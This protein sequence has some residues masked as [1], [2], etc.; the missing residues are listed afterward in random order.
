MVAM[1]LR[2]PRSSALLLI[3]CLASAAAAYRA[4]T[5]DDSGPAGLVGLL[6]EVDDAQFQLDLLTG[7]LDGLR[8]RK[9]VE[10]P[11]RWPA[12]YA[13][14]GKSPNAEVR[15]QA[16]LLALKFN[17]PQALASLRKTVTDARPFGGGSERSP[18]DGTP[19]R[20]RLAALEAL[21]EK[22]APGLAPLLHGLLDDGPLR[23]AALKG[24][25]ACDDPATPR[26]VLGRYA[27]FS[28][29]EKQEAI[30][31]LASR[32]T[33]ARA[34]LDA[35]GDD[36]VPAADVSAFTARQLRNLGDEQITRRLKEVWGEVR[37]T[38]KEKQA[39][40]AK[41]KRLLTK[42]ALSRADLGQGRRVYD[43]T[44]GKCHKLFGAGV[45]IGP[46]LTG[47]NRA[48]LHYV[49]ENV[50]DP[51]AVVAKGYR[52]T[53]VLTVDGRLIAGII[54]AET[55]ASLTL[56]TTEERV[57]IANEDIDERETPAISMMPDG[58]FDTLSDRQIC[59]LIAYLAS[60]SQVPLPP[61]KEAEAEPKP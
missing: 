34:L 19:P 39:L 26:A 45:D 13:K 31:T 49:L 37:Q 15:R 38:S 4:E 1:M 20:E 54:V 36:V 55:N 28:R 18:T 3:A 29:T 2:C 59:D 24:L 27:R 10:M 5:S 23:S 48:D 43:E 30:H 56:Q 17:D 53:N 40:I 42:A 47:S 21:V 33:Y 12:V 57:V 51:G 7:M 35:V 6:A 52:L 22:R 25:A 44:C 32:R 61:E 16:M 9:E 46:D 41:Y 58:Q 8:G 11:P 50:L 14:L 60:K